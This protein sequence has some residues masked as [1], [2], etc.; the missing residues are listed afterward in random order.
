[1]LTNDGTELDNGTKRHRS[2]A[3]WVYQRKDASTKRP[4]QHP[5]Q[6]PVIHVSGD[7]V[8]PTAPK[9]EPPSKTPTEDEIKQAISS[10]QE[11]R[12]F[13]VSR[14][15][16]AAA[17]KQ[18]TGGNIF[19]KERQGPTLFVERTKRK[20]LLAKPRRSLAPQMSS[21][22]ELA[23][24][25]VKQKDLKRPG[26]SKRAVGESAEASTKELLPESMINRHNEDMDKIAAD[27]NEWVLR[28]VGAS[29]HQ[30]EEDKKAAEKAR[31]KPKAPAQRYQE[32]HPQLHEVDTEMSNT[33]TPTE[34]SDEDGEE[35]EDWII[36]EYIRVPA[37]YMAIDVS[38]SDIGVL[39]LEGEEDT[40]L[41]YGAQNDDDD[42]LGE[43]EEDENAEN[44]YTA[45]YPEDEV[46][47]DD[48]YGR[49]PYWFR[50]KNASDDEEFDEDEYD[51]DDMATEADLDDDARMAR[52][53]ARMKRHRIQTEQELDYA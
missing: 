2:E 35:G 24:D 47:S 1:M 13:H 42:E 37:N 17:A 11:Q 38:P 34:M 40:M 43:D 27:M 5:N 23:T 22:Q 36:E 16:L 3:N 31:F 29:L 25:D 4:G 10:N 39:V 53:V 33:A 12:R 32:R 46:A 51:S 26:V 6:V 21:S 14:A 19:K 20:R 8:A 49:N 28:E 30:I 7:I 15:M 18:P 41:F 45:D 44:H 48:E 50:N 52:I 9:E